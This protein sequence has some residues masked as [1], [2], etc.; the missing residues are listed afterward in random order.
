MAWVRK[1]K[2]G[3]VACYK[4]RQ[5]RNRTL[6][7]Q[8]FT[9]KK[10]A[11]NAAAEAEQKAQRR[12]ASTDMTWGE[13]RDKWLAN[14]DVEASTASKDRERIDF[15]LTPK[16]G[17]WKLEDITRP[18]VKDWLTELYAADDEGNPT[19]KPATVNRI[20]GTFSKSLKEAVE[21][22]VLDAN[23]AQ[24][25]RAQGGQESHERFLTKDE[26]KATL[27]TINPEWRRLANFLAYTGV[28]W[29]EASA[30]Y[31]PVIARRR[32]DR[33]KGVVTIAEV[34]DDE[35]ELL[36][37]YPK[38]RKRRD[39]PVPRWVL[40]EMPSKGHVVRSPRGERP[41]RRNLQRALDAGAKRA[42]VDRFRVHD[43]RHTYA[44]WLVDAGVPLEKVRDLLGHKDLTTTQRYVHGSAAG[45]D[46]ILS[47][48]A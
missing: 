32:I 14:R 43:L 28:R 33:Q 4:D 9:H 11:Q 15:H 48:L 30:F 24:G 47:A 40:D 22:E 45:A 42:G 21:D 39:V 34:W 6:K 35:N 7:G 41:D 38:G 23:P 25:V 19:R 5:G 1:N 8:T 26:L 12:F 10:A 13:W 29:G 36:K 44:S 16:W 27:S 20:V 17:D 46:V 31:D 2:S 3:Y 37:L 18:D